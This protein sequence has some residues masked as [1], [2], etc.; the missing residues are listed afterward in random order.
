MEFKEMRDIVGR[1]GEG[2][3]T[4]PGTLAAAV[5]FSI[6]GFLPLYWKNCWSAY[7]P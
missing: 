1:S 6:W 5:T 7:L 3:E 2:S 4:R